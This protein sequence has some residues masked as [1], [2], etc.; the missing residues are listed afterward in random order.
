MFINIIENTFK[1]P[2]ELTIEGVRK[3]EYKMDTIKKSYDALVEVYDLNKDKLAQR[4]I[5][6]I[7]EIS[8][9]MRSWISDYA[10]KILT[11]GKVTLPIRSITDSPTPVSKIIGDSM[12]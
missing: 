3:M 8:F 4:K 1:D 11:K 2:N 6:I 10:S 5:K 7:K 12:E 9:Y